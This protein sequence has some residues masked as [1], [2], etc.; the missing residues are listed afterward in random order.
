MEINGYDTKRRGSGFH[1]NHENQ[2]DKRGRSEERKVP[3]G[4]GSGLE[5]NLNAYG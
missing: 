1:A 2:S 4:N 5:H 3:A